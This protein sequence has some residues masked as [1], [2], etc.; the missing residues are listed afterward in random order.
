MTITT[1][2]RG[3]LLVASPTLEDPNFRRAVVFVLD[4][5]DDGAVGVILNRPSDTPLVEVLP[6]WGDVVALP[7]VAFMGGP[8]SPQAAICL[9]R[10]RRARRAAVSG[11]Q[12]VEGV[13]IVDL[14]RNVNDVESDVDELRVFAGYAGWDTAQLE[15][16]MGLAAWFVVPAEVGDVLTTQPD[17][18]WRDVL[19]RQRGDLRMLATFPDDPSL[20]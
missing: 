11:P 12:P 5:N 9:G 10:V 17:R 1:S 19:R 8:V 3:Q 20:N 4:H 6:D 2:L 7:D 18:L 16:E 14:E 15:F 13:A